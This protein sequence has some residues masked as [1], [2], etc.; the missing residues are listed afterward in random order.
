MGSRSWFFGDAADWEGTPLSYRDDIQPRIQR[1]ESLE[2]PQPHRG[3]YG[4]FPISRPKA[5]SP[6]Y[7][8]FTEAMNTQ[9]SLVSV[10]NRSDGSVAPGCG[11]PDLF[12][13]PTSL[14]AHQTL[15]TFAGQALAMKRPLDIRTDT[16]VVSLAGN[17]NGGATGVRIVDRDGSIQTV[18]ASVIVLA[19]GAIGSAKIVDASQEPFGSTLGGGEAGKN[20]WDCPSVVLQFKSHDPIGTHHCYF[21]TVVQH[22][23]GAKLM[24]QNIP[25]AT[26]SSY[27]DVMALWSSSGTQ[28]PDVKITLQPFTMDAKGNVPA[29]IESGFQITIQLA[30]PTSRGAVTSN[31]VDPNYFA[32]EVDRVAL[33]KAVDMVKEVIKKSTSF[34]KVCD[35]VPFA[36]IF[37]SQGICGGSLSLG[38]AIDATTHLVHGT[39]NVYCCDSSILPKPLIGDRSPFAMALAERFVDRYFNKGDVNAR[40]QK[41]TP[42]TSGET[43]IVF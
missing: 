26:A 29:G 34:A 40:I 37:E 13:D 3:K 1:L 22:L 42:L 27:D 39:S 28:T 10:L 38:K 24:M 14:V 18:G 35:P 5:M 43:R 7:R 9:M 33:R 12:V 2:I 6:L 4:K 20:F 25:V 23:V 36:E 11:R 32:E 16:R 21:D 19:A 8:P 15:D 17:G 30:R 41:G 31:A